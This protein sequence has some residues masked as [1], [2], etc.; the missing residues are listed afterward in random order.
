MAELV[1]RTEDE[2]DRFLAHNA[3][4]AWSP[5]LWVDCCLALAEWAMWL[6]YPDPVAHLRGTYAEGQGQVD[7]LVRGG[8]AVSLVS[9]CARA[10]GAKP[11]TI[12]A[13]GDVGVVGSPTNI[14]RQ[15]GVI[16]DGSGWLTRSRTGWSRLTG[17]T[18]SAWKI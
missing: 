17:R 13:R 6:G 15:F 1:G 11:T 2:L 12:P 14:I 9:A 7:A 4:L 10:I 5:G 8:G 18:L 16:H 3:S